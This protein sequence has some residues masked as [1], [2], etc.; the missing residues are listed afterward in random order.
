M[1][2]LRI[3]FFSLIDILIGKLVMISAAWK[4]I[5]TWLSPEAVKKIKFVSKNDVQEYINKDQLWE[6][7]GGTVSECLYL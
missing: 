7:M 5:K 4:I 3:D 2:C 6:H 1:C